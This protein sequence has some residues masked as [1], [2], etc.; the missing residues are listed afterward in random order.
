M[1][2][3]KYYDRNAIEK[4]WKEYWEAEQIYSF[5]EES[6]K[7]AFTIDTPPPTVSGKMHIGHAYSYAQGD[8]FARYHRMKGENVFYPFG[9]DDNGLPTERLIE[10]M[11]KVYAPN[12]RR[13]AFVAL[14]R[15]TLKEITPA[16]IQPWKDGGF[17]CD[18]EKS[19]STLDALSQKTAQLTFLQLH[20]K[21]RVYQEESPVAWCTHCQT[22]IAQAEFENVPMDS[23]F[24]NIIFKI[25][26]KDLVIATTRP[27]LLAACVALF[28]HP[29]DK[30]YKDLVG[31]HAT[32][33]IFEHEAPILTDIKVDME[34]GTG[35]VMCCTFGDKV[36]IEWW[37]EYKLPQKVIFDKDGSLNN[38]AKGYEGM[39]IKDARKKILEELT[40]KKLLVTQE[41]ITHPV[42]VHDKCGT[43]LEFIETE[44]WFVKILDKKQDLIH[45]GNKITWYPPFMRKRYIH[46]VENLNWDW[47]ISRQRFFGVPF[48]VWY[49]GACGAVILAE[50][51][52]L[53]VDPLQSQPKKKC[54]CGNDTFIPEKDVFDT[55]FTSGSTPQIAL[56]LIEN[57]KSFEQHYPMNLHLQAHDIIRTWAFYII[58]KSLYL[59]NTI[60]WENIVISGF[61]TVKGKKMSKSKGNVIDPILVMRNHGADALRFWAASKKAGED[62][63]Y[64]EKDVVTGNK[65]ITKLWNA[66]K[67]CL[68][69]LQ[70]YDFTEPKKLEII[71]QWIFLEL[72]ELVKT[73]TE[74]FEA[75][76]YAKAKQAWENFFWRTFCD[77]YLEIIKDRLYHKDKRGADAHKSARYTLS[78]VLETLLK[79]IAPIMP[80]ITEE[81]YQLFFVK[82]EKLKSI[83]V[84]PWPHVSKH[85]SLKDITIIGQTFVN[86]LTDVRQMKSK[87]NKSLNTEITLHITKKDNDLLKGCI[88]DLQAATKA[89]DIKV[90]TFTV[91]F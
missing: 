6:K 11:K 80:Y 79:L 34:K 23:H 87:N 85:K 82:E 73:C 25:G 59:H 75:Y 12:T 3:P 74:S 36:D 47:C 32:V 56:R 61:I 1:E 14:C 83:H 45:M 51:K 33:P 88:E 53:P 44:Q 31:K 78:T 17:S 28:V 70:D 46:W 19:Y 41:K 20:K 37:I 38:L 29:D 4:K 77:N 2:L 67:F 71:D 35:A 18:F 13:N 15:D 5:N 42:N 66:T 52:D 91:D 57:K 48:P 27:E 60:P 22:A 81:I 40:E 62:F 49:C 65:T 89:K 26:G 63:D 68:T 72:D 9:T 55:W 10:K 8:F 43:E 54:S 64:E 30:R 58:T 39:K 84:S 16:F 90:G 76:D 50:E 24:N 69:H 21:G 7:P 86:I